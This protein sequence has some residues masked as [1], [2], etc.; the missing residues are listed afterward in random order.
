[1]TQFLHIYLLLT[2]KNCEIGNME[3]RGGAVD[4]CWQFINHRFNDHYSGPSE[5]ITSGSLQRLM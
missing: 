1:M 2:I 5:S 3:E 4:H